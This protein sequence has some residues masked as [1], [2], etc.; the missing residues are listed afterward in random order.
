M[1][2]PFAPRSTTMELRPSRSTWI[3]ACPVVEPTV[4]MREVSAPASRSG[5]S[6]H[7]PSEPMAPTRHTCAPALAS[8]MVW[9]KP[10]PP[11]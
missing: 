8:A 2:R 6:S 10:L 7:V 9:L 3:T 1:I 11:G 5:T 4:A